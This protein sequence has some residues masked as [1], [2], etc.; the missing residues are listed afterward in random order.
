MER[1]PEKSNELLNVLRASWTRNYPNKP[2]FLG[3]LTTGP[4]TLKLYKTEGDC[5]P[6]AVK[7]IL[8]YSQQNYKLLGG[9]LAQTT[10]FVN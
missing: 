1:H 3:R 4:R 6:P 5:I 9:Y 2:L 10:E 8:N 7:L